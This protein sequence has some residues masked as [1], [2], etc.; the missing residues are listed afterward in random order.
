[1]SAIMPNV[2]LPPADDRPPRARPTMS[3]AKFGARATGRHQMLTSP[4]DSCR[5]GFLPNS[6]DHGAHNSQPNAYVIKKTAAP[7][8]AA[9]MLTPNS[10]DI[11]STPFEYSDVLKFI[12]VC[13]RK[14]TVRI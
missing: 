14:M 13:T 11:P 8:R 10:L 4:K 9:C 2:T 5:I 12:D 1:M 3:V 7:A 6:S